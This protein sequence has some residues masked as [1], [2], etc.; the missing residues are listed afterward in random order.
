[1]ATPSIAVPASL[2]G[3]PAETRV[4]ATPWSRMVRGIGLG[5]HP[6]R[7]DPLAASRIRGAFDRLAKTVPGN[8]YTRFSG[9]LAE[10]VLNFARPGLSDQRAVRALGPI[11]EAA[12]AVPNPYWR[13][14]AGCIL[15]D[16]WA[17]LGLDSAL[18]TDGD[19]DIP[20]ETLALVDAVAPDQIKDENQGR[21]GDYERLSAYTAVFLAHGQLGLQAR[22]TAGRDHVGEALGLIDRVPSP[23]FRGRGGSMLIAVTALIGHGDRLTADGRDAIGEILDYLDRDDEIGMPPAFP[24]PLSTAFGKVYPLLTM[25]NA[26]AVAGRPDHLLRGRDRLAQAR[27]LMAALDPAERTHMGLYYLMALSNLGRLRAQVPSLDRYLESL[28]GTWRHLD[29]GENFFLTGIAYPYLIQT[30]MLTGRMD[31]VPHAMLERVADSYPDL[32]RT[33]EDRVNR[34]YPF[35][36][37]VNVLGEIGAA[38]LVFEPRPRYGGQSA[39]DWV[40]DR[41]SPDGEAEGS[42]LYILD[43]ALIAYAL[44]QRGGSGDTALFAGHRFPFDRP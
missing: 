27:D 14:M 36:Y 23:F 12:R 11:M 25:L 28:V 34:P 31:L 32:D 20:A 3:L 42:R 40:I 38:D 37:L 19:A 13:I 4:I 7:Y 18:L 41:L 16:A 30:A 29:P 26:V 5:Q 22:L 43:H 21:H 9:H 8:A 35:G 24:Q 2:D 44:R 33:D 17:K 39:M 6:V 1:M 10:L 15:M